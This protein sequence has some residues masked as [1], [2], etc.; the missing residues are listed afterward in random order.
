MP[1]TA[2]L[3]TLVMLAHLTHRVFVMPDH[4]STKLFLLEG[5]AKV[6]AFYCFGDVSEWVLVISMQQY[7]DNRQASTCLKSRL[8]CLTHQCDAA[9]PSF[10]RSR[11]ELDCVVCTSHWS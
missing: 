6:S 10:I 2:Q 8:S 4:L 3:E 9:C 1:H 11:A 7:L 5:S